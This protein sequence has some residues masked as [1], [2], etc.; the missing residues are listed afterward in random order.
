LAQARLEKLDLR[1]RFAAGNRVAFEA[2]VQP[3]LDALY[4]LTLRLTGRAEVAEDIAQEALVK[5]LASCKRYDPSRPFRPWLLTIARNVCRDRQRSA[6]LKRV[7]VLVR[8]VIDPRADTF[9]ELAAKERDALVRSALATLPL[10]YREAVALFHLEDMS[11]A[12]MAE[13]TGSSV[14][15]LKQR[16]RR[17]NQM[18]KQALERMYPQLLGD[19]IG[20]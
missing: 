10:T 8:P 19:R 1:E 17:G 2:L 3:E 11:Y 5:A 6:W 18:L 9:D 15:A 16:V 14:A 12:E 13:I 20:S 4:T 7:I